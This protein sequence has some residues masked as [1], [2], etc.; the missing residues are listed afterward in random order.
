MTTQTKKPSSIFPDYP[1]EQPIVEKNGHLKSKWDFSL[2]SLYQAL[3]VNFSNEG[4][5]FPSLNA[6]DIATIEAIYNPSLIGSPLPQN[7]PDISGKTIF[8][9]TNRVPKIFIITYDGSGNILTAAWK[10]FT[11]T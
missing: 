2:N 8:D 6:A 9:S 10:T 11:L 7:I 1:R 5:L 4:I 3:Q